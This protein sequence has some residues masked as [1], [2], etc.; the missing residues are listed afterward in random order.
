[1]PDLPGGSSAAP[2]RYQTIWVTTG[3][4]WFVDH[5]HLQAV[6]QGEGLGIEHLR[7]RRGGA[8]SCRAMKAASAAAIRV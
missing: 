4:R 3:A 6:G 8:G 5:H 2:T 1:M 7:L